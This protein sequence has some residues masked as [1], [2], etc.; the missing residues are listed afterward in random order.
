[1]MYLIVAHMAFFILPNG[2]KIS[3]GNDEYIVDV[4][5]IRMC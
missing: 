2:R 3:F 5:D 4:L 1:M